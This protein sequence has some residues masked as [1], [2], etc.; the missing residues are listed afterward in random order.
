[1]K[2]NYAQILDNSDKMKFSVYILLLYLRSHPNHP[3]DPSREGGF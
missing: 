1:M 3:H 2:E